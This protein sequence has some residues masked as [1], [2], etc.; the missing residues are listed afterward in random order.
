MFH[1]S[2]RPGVSGGDPPET[3]G[4]AGGIPRDA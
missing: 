2:A 4:R 1:L 3:V